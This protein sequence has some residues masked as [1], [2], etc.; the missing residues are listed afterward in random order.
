M[1]QNYRRL[2]FFILM[3]T[4]TSISYAKKTELLFAYQNSD[5]YPF[6]TGNSQDIDWGKP[7]IILELLKIVEKEA[8][9][10]I[11]FKRLPWKRA[12]FE[13]KNGH[14]DGV[15]A[16]SYKSKR[17]AFGAYP[18]NNGKVDES[19]R[20]HVNSYSLYTL[21][22]SKV[23]WD[24]K[25]FKNLSTHVCAERAYSIVDDLQ[26][27]GV[28]VYEVNNTKKCME[29][30][31]NGRVE[32][33]AALELA[34]DAILKNQKNL[35]VKIQKLQPTLKTKAYFL[36]LSHKLVEKES[37]ISKK[38]WD[39]IKAVRESKEMMDINAKYFQ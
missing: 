23:T 1:L 30:L 39:T 6:Q 10:K 21:K 32:A 15:F 14:V 18:K 24:G 5:N 19:R 28:K 13:L 25:T 8:D 2:L 29:L 34:G 20:T 26:K 3:I 17:L 7:G 36:M 27:M 22:K 35:Y 4:L 16:A 38:I 31:A 33:V 37:G 9:I 11:N 12:L